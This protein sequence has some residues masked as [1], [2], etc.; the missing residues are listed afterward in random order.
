MWHQKACCLLPE[1]H[2]E[3]L[4]LRCVTGTG[5]QTSV[6]LH[7]FV[8]DTR[9]LPRRS[10]RHSGSKHTGK[11]VICCQMH[12]LCSLEIQEMHWTV[13]RWPT[14]TT[15]VE[16]LWDLQSRQH[17]HRCRQHAPDLAPWEAGHARVATLLLDRKAPLELADKAGTHRSSP[18]SEKLLGW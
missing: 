16:L 10:F 9:R 3:G 18:A 7:A 8:T 11:F 12:A 1:K 4:H 6:P 5:G 17:P 14:L 13:R 2:F 15:M